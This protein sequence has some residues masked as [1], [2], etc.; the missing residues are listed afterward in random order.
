MFEFPLRP[1]R[2]A[3]GACVILAVGIS[4][5]GIVRVQRYVVPDGGVTYSCS[6]GN[7]CVE[8]SSTGS[9]YGVYGLSSG[10]NGVEGRSSAAGQAG[11][12]GVQLGDSGFGVYAESHDTSKKYAALFS[13]GDE[14][15][16]NIFYGENA[17]THSS[18]LIDP[19]SNLTCTGSIEGAPS[20]K[21]VG[22]MGDSAQDYG[23]EGV[24]GTADGVHG[25][26]NSTIG[27]SAV[28]GVAQGTTGTGYGV[29]GISGNGPGVLAPALLATA[30]KALRPT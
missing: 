20:Q 7:A 4:C 6:T 21:L 14:K 15:A 25:V 19:N 18:C 11:V 29:F 27:N 24:S 10:G 30:S 28:A 8:G 13:R 3:I 22:V 5:L 12:A 2:I 17:A 16:T 9:P 26:T 1:K 23:V